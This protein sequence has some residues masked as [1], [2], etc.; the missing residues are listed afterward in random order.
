[1]NEEQ[2]YAQAVVEWLTAGGWEVYQEVVTACGRCDI[3]ATKGPIR[4]AIEVK[5]SLNLAVLDQ[6]RQN[7]AWFHHSSIAVPAPA[8]NIHSTPRTWELAHALAELLGFGV[9]R[10]VLADKLGY[11]AGYRREGVVMQ[12]KLPRLNRRPGTVK[13]HEEQKTW[14]AAGSSGGGHFTRFQQTVQRLTG[15]VKRSPGIALK[16]AIKGTDHHYAS[17]ASAT[18]A[19]SKMIR[20]GIIEG[21]RLDN[22]KL[23]PLTAQTPLPAPLFQ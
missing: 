16:E 14:C 6:A 9:I 19:I 20:G 13:L 1:M 10:I 22:G 7:L 18:G 12:D 21:L 15:V 3:V 4:W 11:S 17:V 23:Y 2:K 5:T 8:R